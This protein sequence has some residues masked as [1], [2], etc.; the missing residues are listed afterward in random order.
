MQ[1][2]DNSLISQFLPSKIDIP[3]IKRKLKEELAKNHP[4]LCIT[5]EQLDA[6]VDFFISVIYIA[7][8]LTI[9]KAKVSPKSV[10]KFDEKCKEVQ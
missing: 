4:N 1:I 6:Q 3:L 9:P 7:M 8:D 2:I 5:V 10:S